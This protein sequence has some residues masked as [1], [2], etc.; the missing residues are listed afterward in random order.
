MEGQYFVEELPYERRMDITT[1]RELKG[2]AGLPEYAKKNPDRM[3]MDQEF[4]DG[5]E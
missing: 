4:M 5:C 2:K 3:V 1:G